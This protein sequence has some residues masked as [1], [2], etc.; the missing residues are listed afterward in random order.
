MARGKLGLLRLERSISREGFTSSGEAP[1]VISSRRPHL[2]KCS[3]KTTVR[4]TV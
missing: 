1:V 4:M 2:T 3:V